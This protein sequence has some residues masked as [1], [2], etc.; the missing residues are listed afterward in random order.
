MEKPLILVTGGARSG[1]S[2]FAQKLAEAV[3][4]RKAFIATAEPLDH[5]MKQ[6]ITLHRKK[7]PAGWNTVEEGY[8]VLLIDCLTL[9]ISNLMVNKNM[10]EKAILKN[11]SNLVTSCKEIPS[12]VI[13]VTNELGMGIVPAN[14][15]SRLYRDLV[16]KANQ[17][18]AAEADEVYFLVSGIP[19]KLKG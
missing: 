17:Q 8:D 2:C 10:K 16:G 5:E 6:R 9:W 1:K 12:R 3:K 15:L 18:I 19:M 7:R 14:R 13:M 11:I 4:G